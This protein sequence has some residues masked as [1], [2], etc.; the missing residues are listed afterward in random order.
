MAMSVGG[1][2]R[3]IA[4]GEGRDAGEWRWRDQQSSRLVAGAANAP[5]LCE[6]RFST[7]Q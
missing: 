3:V 2:R 4:S 6:R 7:V 1:Q 5:A